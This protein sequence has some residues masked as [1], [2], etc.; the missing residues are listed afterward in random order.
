LC[1]PQ[2]GSFVELVPFDTHAGNQPSRQRFEP[3]HDAFSSCLGGNRDPS[4]PAGVSEL[5]RGP[6]R[7][8]GGQPLSG[9]NRADGYRLVPAIAQNS[10]LDGSDGAPGETFQ[11]GSRP[12]FGNVDR[13]LCGVSRP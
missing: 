5:A 10:H 6:A 4:V 8:L 3:E 2:Q 1:F 13:S 9:A 12:N 7:S 11:I